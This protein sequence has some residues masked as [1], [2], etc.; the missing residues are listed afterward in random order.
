M[1][2]VPFLYCPTLHM[3]V[4]FCPLDVTLWELRLGALAQ[5]LVLWLLL[6]L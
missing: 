5:M 3:Q 1:L 6:L 2:R 4:S